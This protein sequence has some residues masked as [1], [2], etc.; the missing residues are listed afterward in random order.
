MAADLPD[1]SIV[2]GNV[3]MLRMTR[4]LPGK[5]A[6]TWCSNMVSVIK[7]VGRNIET[8]ILYDFIK[9]CL[10]KKCVI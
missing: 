8:P 6:A 9:K 5:S 4:N 10:T 1:K 2:L 7:F 3:S